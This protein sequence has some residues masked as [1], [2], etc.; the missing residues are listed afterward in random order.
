MR[1]LVTLCVLLL[2]VGGVLGL[3][4]DRWMLRGK[5]VQQLKVPT[6]RENALQKARQT[7]VIVAGPCSGSSTTCR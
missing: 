4:F 3:I 2:V 1:V 5:N 7:W 6:E